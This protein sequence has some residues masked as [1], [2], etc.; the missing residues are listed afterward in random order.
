MGT[1]KNILFLL[2]FVVMLVPVAVPFVLQLKILL[3]ESDA[4]ERLERNHLEVLHIPVENILWTK[5]GKEIIT[6]NRLFDVKEFSQNKNEIVV[7][8]IFDDVET[9]LEKQMTG[10]WQQQQSKQGIVLF[11]Y[12]QLLA[13]S[14]LPQAFLQPGIISTAQKIYPQEIFCYHKEIF[15]KIPTPPPQ[16]IIIS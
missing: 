13:Q 6:N 10:L 7:T 5:Q 4:E 15:I 16:I 11:K 12:F 1:I 9:A 14:H 2:L 3:V 8:G